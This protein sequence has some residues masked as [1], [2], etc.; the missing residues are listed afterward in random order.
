MFETVLQTKFPPVLAD[1]KLKSATAGVKF[2]AYHN[3][4]A[5]HVSTVVWDF[6]DA[7]TQKIIQALI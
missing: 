5:P 1:P 2:L 3:K 7:N 6:P 4:E